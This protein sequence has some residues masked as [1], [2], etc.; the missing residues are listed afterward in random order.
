VLTKA[1]GT[2]IMRPIKEISVHGKSSGQFP[3]FAIAA[4]DKNFHAIFIG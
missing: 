1:I 3:P 4:D 2:K